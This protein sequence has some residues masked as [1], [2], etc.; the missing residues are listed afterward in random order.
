MPKA[1]HPLNSHPQA[2]WGWGEGLRRLPTLGFRLAWP[3]LQ[4]RQREGRLSLR[5]PFP[6]LAMVNC[7]VAL[8]CH[9][10]VRRGG[11][12][13]DSAGGGFLFLSIPGYT[14]QAP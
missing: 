13:E 11:E 5:F 2:G 1:F 10:A 14:V 8:S 7:G 6:C 3:P 4:Q 12:V 9:S